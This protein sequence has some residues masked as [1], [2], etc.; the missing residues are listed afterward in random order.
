MSLSF[1]P[2]VSLVGV[3][4]PVIFVLILAT[5]MTTKEVTTTEVEEVENT[6][7]AVIN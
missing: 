4:L 3:E 5:T 2:K 6:G 1:L 7:A